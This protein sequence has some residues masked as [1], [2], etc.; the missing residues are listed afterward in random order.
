MI[1]HLGLNV[2]DLAGAADRW[3]SFA[4]L[5]GMEANH[6]D[7]TSFSLR[8]AEGRKG[9]Y[10]FFYEAEMGRHDARTPGLQHLA[11]AVRTRTAVDRVHAEAIDRGLCIQH[12]PRT[13][14]EYPQPY[15]ATFWTDPDDFVLEAVCH[16]D[17]D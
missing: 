11:F 6:L 3:L 17:E 16:R 7:S 14:R 12:A 4:P 10:L 8:P 2:S 1:G 9:A 13:F 15:Y 5:L